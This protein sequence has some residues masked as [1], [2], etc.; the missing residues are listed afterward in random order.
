MRSSLSFLAVAWTHGFPEPIGTVHLLGQQK[1]R[2][3]L[4]TISLDIVRKETTM[5]K[6]TTDLIGCR[7]VHKFVYVGRD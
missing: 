7:V 6:T 1:E 4:N 2:L 5:I 3:G